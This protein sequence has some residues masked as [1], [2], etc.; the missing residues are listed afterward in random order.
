MGGNSTKATSGINGAGTQTQQ[1]LGIP[2]SAK[3]FFED[4][5][6]SVSTHFTT[7]GRIGV[8]IEGGMVGALA[9]E[10]LGRWAV[11]TKRSGVCDAVFSVYLGMLLHNRRW[12]PSWSPCIHKTKR[13]ALRPIL[14]HASHMGNRSF[15]SAYESR[16]TETRAPRS[17]ICRLLSVPVED[18]LM[19]FRWGAT[20]F[21]AVFSSSILYNLLLTN[22]LS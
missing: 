21:L 17:R 18:L 22:L 4:T 12:M 3:T 19:A 14:Y 6:K 11:V 20:L 5:K 13:T 16:E 15:A 1:E 8:G 7:S 2:D 10:M 9:V